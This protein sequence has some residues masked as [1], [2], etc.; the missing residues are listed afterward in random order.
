MTQPRQVDEGGLEPTRPHAKKKVA[1]KGEDA[2]LKR[3]LLTARPARPWKGKTANADGTQGAE[4]RQA[5]GLSTSV[6]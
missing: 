5:A 4:S 1:P 3:V 6:G 2:F